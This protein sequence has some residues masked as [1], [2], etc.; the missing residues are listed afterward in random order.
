MIKHEIKPELKI[1]MMVTRNDGSVEYYDADN[2]EIMQIE[3]NE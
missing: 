3:E 2:V 1:T